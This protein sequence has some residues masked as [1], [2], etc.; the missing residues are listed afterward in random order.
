LGVLRRRLLPAGRPGTWRTLWADQDADRL[1][2]A[3]ADLRT[4]PLFGGSQVLVLRTADKLREAEQAG[5]LDALPTLG[6]GGTLVLAGDGD[7][8][9]L[10]QGRGADGSA[11]PPRL[12]GRRA[13]AAPA[14]RRGRLAAPGGRLPRRQPAPRAPRGRAGGAGAH[15]RPGRRAARH[16]ALAGR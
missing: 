7:L 15:T 11:R 9:A 10:P 4:P 13:G 8:G 12:A 5:V 1:G 6:A 14:A 2:D 16:A 3:L